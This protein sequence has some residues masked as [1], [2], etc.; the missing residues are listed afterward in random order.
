[1]KIGIYNIYIYSNNT[2]SKAKVSITIDDAIAINDI[3][4]QENDGKYYLLF[5]NCPN[6]NKQGERHQIVHPVFS[7][8][9]G[10]LICDKTIPAN[11]ATQPT[12]PTQVMV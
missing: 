4:L 12:S 6:N 2:S 3:I 11:M 1:M 8:F 9:V 5:P 7:F 10:N